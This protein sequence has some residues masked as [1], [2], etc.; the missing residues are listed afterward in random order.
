MDTANQSRRQSPRLLERVADAATARHLSAS[1]QKAYVRW[2]LRFVLFH[3]KRHPRDMGVT[4][5]NTFLTHLAVELHVSASTQNQALSI[6]RSARRCF[7][8][9]R[10]WSGRS[11]RS[12]VWCG[13]NGQG[14]CPWC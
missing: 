4:E 10:S 7:C 2:I 5:V 11:A 6:K 9:A 14:D 3:R 13:R 1:T 12:R 8:M